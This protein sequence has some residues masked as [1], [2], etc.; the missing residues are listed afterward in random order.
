MLVWATDSPAPANCMTTRSA[1]VLLRWGYGVVALGERDLMAKAGQ[2]TE[3]ALVR[4]C[5]AVDELPHG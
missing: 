1:R 4:Y 5:Q 3:S 2:L